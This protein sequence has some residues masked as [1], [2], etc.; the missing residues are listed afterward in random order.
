MVFLKSF[1]LSPSREDILFKDPQTKI[2][3]HLSALS[4]AKTNDIQVIRKA[5]IALEAIISSSMLV[6]V[7]PYRL[8]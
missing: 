7:D 3:I 8:R 5:N 2:L 4:Q 1:L 6:Q